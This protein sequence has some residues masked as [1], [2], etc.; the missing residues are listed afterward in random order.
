MAMMTGGQ[1]PQMNMTPMVDILL[2]LLIIFM[3]ITPTAPVG[4]KAAL[5]QDGPASDSAPPQPPVVIRVEH[6]GKASVNTEPVS[7]AD[8]GAKLLSIF[9]ARPGSTVF[10]D[11]ADDLAYGDVAHVID[12]AKGAGISTVGLMPRR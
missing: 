8:L 1:G 9:R 5:P 7:V 6:D 3:V 12:I 10:V 2:V 11:G 4:L